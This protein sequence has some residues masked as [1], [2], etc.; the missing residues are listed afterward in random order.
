MFRL[1]REPQDNNAINEP[2]LSYG[3]D[4]ELG[5]QLIRESS[6]EQESFAMIKCLKM[7]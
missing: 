5:P 4:N 3:S 7:T 2:L 6:L 1:L